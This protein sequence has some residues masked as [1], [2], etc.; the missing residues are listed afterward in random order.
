MFYF[1]Q[2]LLSIIVDFLEIFR[3]GYYELSSLSNPTIN[4]VLPWITKWKTHCLQN[5]DESPIFAALKT[6]MNSSIDQEVVKR[7]TIHHKLATFLDPR[8]KE[9]QFLT[10]EDQL[11]TQS[12]AKN[13]VRECRETLLINGIDVHN[14]SSAN[15]HFSEF[16]DNMSINNDEIQVTPSE[17]VDEYLA[18]E[19]N[20]GR[21]DL[22]QEKKFSPLQH[23]IRAKT[24]PLL[25]QSCSMDFILSSQYYSN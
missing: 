17:E 23:W 19:F 5:E 22:D 1:D 24:L 9:L 13:M 6:F 12:Y 21:N 25:E 4:L 16:S 18:E 10:T 20:M 15:D 14:V 11:E 8:Y 2:E 3:E 7:I